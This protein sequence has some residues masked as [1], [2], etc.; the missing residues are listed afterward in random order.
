MS[1]SPS[2][3]SNSWRLEG[4]LRTESRVVKVMDMPPLMDLDAFLCSLLSS[5]SATPAVWTRVGEKWLVF[6]QHGEACD[7]LANVACL[8]PALE[9]D[10]EPFHS[11]SKVDFEMQHR[12]S[13]NPPP[14]PLRSSFRLG[15]WI[16][17]NS[18]CSAHNFG[19]NQHCIG[20]GTPR[21]TSVSSPISP[22]F[23]NQATQRLYTTPNPLPPAP[24]PPPPKPSHP[25][26]TP[27]GRTFA[28]GGRVQNISS[29]PLSPCIMYWP[30]N[31]PF[32]DPGQI[33][34]GNPLG[35]AHPPI[36]NTGNRG[37][38]A[39]QPGDWVCKKCNYLNW[40]RRKVC[41]TCLPYAEGN[42]DSISAAVQAERIALLTSV[43]SQT[44]IS[45][46]AQP[47]S[48][49]PRAQPPPIAPSRRS[50]SA[51]SPRHLDRF[52][53]V[54]LSPQ[55][56]RQ[57]Y[58][59]QSLSELGTHSRSDSGLL[60]QTPSPFETIRSQRDPSLLLRPHHLA[61]QRRPE[62]DDGATLLPGFL[63]EIVSSPSGSDPSELSD[64]ET[65]D[66]P[67]LPSPQ[68]AP[69]PLDLKSI[70]KLDNVQL[71]PPKQVHPIQKY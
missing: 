26:L 22:R 12:L 16:C 62:G 27:S 34:P 19:R 13:T 21:V 41:Q 17:P 56:L 48:I 35:V 5:L 55:P 45:P 10:L 9:S 29:D 53:P 36:L 50:V 57:P 42:G 70:W 15:D 28:I 60:Y 39:H 65:D 38:I 33:R 59:C 32:P 1:F 20:C 67:H 51:T 7:A 30:D 4:F 49:S 8:S 47:L 68:R 66:R 58:K 18:K 46:R 31:E 25:I 54:D 69:V 11:L 44:S 2:T 52:D 43:L 64:S 63:Q 14:P 61:V 71:S 40:R 37:P 23:Q 6:Y 24:P 3:S